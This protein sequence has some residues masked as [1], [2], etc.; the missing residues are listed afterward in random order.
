M[1]PGRPK[2]KISWNQ[3]KPVPLSLSRRAHSHHI[4]FF[5]KQ[6]PYAILLRFDVIMMMWHHQELTHVTQIQHFWAEF[7]PVQI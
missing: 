2:N 6:K 3:K 1:D 7:E 4:L 5:V